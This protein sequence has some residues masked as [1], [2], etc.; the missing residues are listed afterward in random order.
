MFVYGYH[1]SYCFAATL[2]VVVALRA[3]KIV[4][5]QQEVVTVEARILEY[6]FTTMN[7]IFLTVVLL[8][9]GSS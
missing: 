3:L 2:W 4:A 1:C 7:T 5:S 6:L 8:R 9:C